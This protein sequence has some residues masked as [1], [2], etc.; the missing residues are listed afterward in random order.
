MIRILKIILIVVLT[1][2]LSNCKATKENVKT[3]PPEVVFDFTELETNNFPRKIGIVSDYENIFSVEELIN[4]NE[5]INKFNIKSKNQIAIASINSIANYTDFDK[6]SL[7]LS[8]HWGVGQKNKD[9]GLTII[10]SKKLKRIRISTGNGTSKILSDETCQTIID[11]IMIPEFK[12]GNYYNG[13]EK[14]LIE[15]IEKWK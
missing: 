13:I 11:N 9:N 3:D 7:D 10:F 8:N 5:I 14:G 2:N 6:Y 15:L 1:F 12:D 4:L